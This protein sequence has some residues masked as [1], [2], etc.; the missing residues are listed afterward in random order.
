VRPVTLLSKRTLG[1]TKEPGSASA[2]PSDRPL[3]KQCAGRICSRVRYRGCPAREYRN[4]SGVMHSWLRSRTPRL[5]LGVFLR[6]SWAASYIAQR[7]VIRKLEHRPMAHLAPVRR[8]CIYS[9]CSGRVLVRTVRRLP[10]ERKRD[11]RRHGARLEVASHIR[12]GVILKIS[13]G[14]LGVLALPI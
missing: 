4:R 8:S 10:R 6:Q 9:I 2:S 1:S 5:S 12:K 14:Q 11:W 13:G 7:P 3:T